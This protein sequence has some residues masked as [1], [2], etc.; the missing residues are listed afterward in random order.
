MNIRQHDVNTKGDI[1]SE[2][3]CHS[4][5][6]TLLPS[7]HDQLRLVDTFW[8]FAKA[9]HSEEAAH[10]GAVQCVQ[11]CIVAK[12]DSRAPQ[13]PSEHRCCMPAER[14]LA[15]PVKSKSHT[16]AQLLASAN[17]RSLN[18]CSAICLRYTVLAMR[19]QSSLTVEALAVFS[20]RRRS[21]EETRNRQCLDERRQGRFE[22]FSSCLPPAML[23]NRCGAL[24]LSS[25]VLGMLLNRRVVAHC[26]FATE[27]CLL[28]GTF[29]SA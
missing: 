25:A 13:L 20:A 2:C 23:V 7:T 6:Y 18:V 3:S 10:Y 8:R 19:L 29:S 17:R 1:E 26:V 22:L 15:P 21:R 9:V 14:Y 24:L 28:G 27:A 5:E 16:A 12:P 11:A 4:A